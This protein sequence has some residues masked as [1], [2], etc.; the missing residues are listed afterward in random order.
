MEI[1]DEA[2]RQVPDGTEGIVRLRSPYSVSG[3]LGDAEETATAFRDGWFYPGDVGCVTRNDL[4]IIAGRAKEILN[5][6]GAKL[7]PQS[8]E[9]ALASFPGV[10]EAA[11]F[12]VSNGLG[13]E[14]PWAAIV[15]GSKLDG[16]E[17]RAHC[18]RLLPGTH[19][20]VQFVTVDALPRNETGK[21]DRSRLVELAKLH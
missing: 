10:V 7:R 5:L 4:L 19:V 20:P 2:G 15:C 16:N 3:Y 9:Q 1:L 14:E 21:L 8:I 18:R 6:G 11:A 17:L 13:I 12:G